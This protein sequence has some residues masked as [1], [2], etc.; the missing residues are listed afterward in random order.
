MLPSAEALHLRKVRKIF[1]AFVAQKFPESRKSRRA[2]CRRAHEKTR[3][4]DRTKA[5]YKTEDTCQG[6]VLI[7]ILAAEIH[8]HCSYVRATEDSNSRTQSAIAIA[9]RQTLVRL[10]Y[11]AQGEVRVSNRVGSKSRHNEV[12]GNPGAIL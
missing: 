9:L 2:S 1:F 3:S 4:R 5:G 12:F 6:K 11:R 8:R 10:L 7:R